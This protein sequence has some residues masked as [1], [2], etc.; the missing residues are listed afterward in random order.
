MSPEG[1]Q[2]SIGD[3]DLS[4]DNEPHATIY[5]KVHFIATH[6]DFNATTYEYDL[7]LLWFY[8][9][10]KFAPNVVPICISKEDSDLIDESGWVTGWGQLYKGM[11]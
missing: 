1:I 8:E 4:S 10:I 7:A 6:P 2:L 3:Y 11:F 9:A 5:R